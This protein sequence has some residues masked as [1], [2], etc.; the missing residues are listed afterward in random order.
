MAQRLKIDE[1]L[2]MA[3]SLPVIDVR[4][5]SEY[6]HAHI[7]GAVSLP[8]FDDQER[9]NVGTRYTKVNRQSAVILGLEYIGPKLTRFAK[10]GIRLARQNQLLLY[11]WRGGMRSESMAWIFETT[12]IQCRI[13][14]GGYKSF[15]K[16]VLESFSRKFSF[17]VLGGYTGSG[18]TELLEKIRV[19]GE[20]VLDLEAMANHRGSAFG[21]I[22]MD[23]QPSNEQF[24]NLLFSHLNRLDTIKPVWVE[25]ESRNIGINL[26]PTALFEQIRNAPVLVAG[27][28][29]D[30]RI[31]RL[32]SHYAQSGKEQLKEAIQKITRRMGG[33]RAKKAVEAIEKGDFAEAAEL[34]LAY[35]D[36][37]YRYGL[38][39]RS[40]EQVHRLDMLNLSI[41]QRV[42]QLIDYAKH[43]LYGN[44]EINTIQSRS[45]MRM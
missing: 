13:L 1:F 28:S 31:E 19:K 20:Q 33:D 38:E 15:R 2:K 14:E 8:L 6:R 30:D 45:G 17:I 36:K 4:S 24:E 25:D 23:P 18:K 42:K 11:C 37:S 21:S 40:P 39:I 22:G 16:H 10:E 43:N 32:L 7:P 5:P 29:T 34:I 44:S 12:G 41:E 35:Y 9:A 26:I 3:A 27:V